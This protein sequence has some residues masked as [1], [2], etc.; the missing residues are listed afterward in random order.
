[1]PWLQADFDARTKGIY[2]AALAEWRVRAGHRRL[3][4][5]I[6]KVIRYDASADRKA[7]NRRVE[8]RL[9]KCA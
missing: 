6:M 7:L 4:E 9:S 5:L 8:I 2:P 1:M 3:E